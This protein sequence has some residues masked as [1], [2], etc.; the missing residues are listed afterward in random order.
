MPFTWAFL[1]LLKEELFE[2]VHG[3]GGILDSVT[4]DGGMVVYFEII[5][6][7]SRFIAKEVNFTEIIDL[8]VAQA[9]GLVPA[10]R[11]GVDRNLPT[12]RVL[13][14]EIWEFNLEGLDQISADAVGL[15]E[16][17]ESQTLLVSAIA[18]DGR[19][20]DHGITEF[21]EAAA[22]NRNIQISNVT[23]C[24]IDQLLVLFFPQEPNEALIKKIKKR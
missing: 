9:E 1:S 6:A 18:S 5:T 14:P 24:E 19:N 12:N 2:L 21:D 17:F 10:L 15:I 23:K 13:Q 22:F 8:Q 4:N 11:E 7:F 3:V 16:G 20:V